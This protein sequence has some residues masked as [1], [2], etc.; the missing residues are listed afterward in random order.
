MEKKAERIEDLPVETEQAAEVKGGGV[1]MEDS[2]P[3]SSDARIQ[4]KWLPA[5]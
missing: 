5:N 4:K 2:A 1:I 3:D